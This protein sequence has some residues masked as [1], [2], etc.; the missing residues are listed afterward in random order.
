M[1]PDVLIGVEP[2]LPQLAAKGL[3]CFKTTF[4][5]LLVGPRSSSRGHHRNVATRNRPLDS[6]LLAGENGY[7]W[8]EFGT[9]GI[10]HV[11]IRSLPTAVS[12][13]RTSTS[14]RLTDVAH[15][16]IRYFTAP[17]EIGPQTRATMV[18]LI[19]VQLLDEQARSVSP[20]VFMALIA[21]V[22]LA[23]LGIPISKL[24]VLGRYEKLARSDLALLGFS[25]VLVVFLTTTFLLTVWLYYGVRSELDAELSEDTNEHAKALRAKLDKL[26][27][28]TKTLQDMHR[29]MTKDR[30]V[31]MALWPEAQDCPEPGPVQAS[32]RMYRTKLPLPWDPPPTEPV[33]PSSIAPI[34]GLSMAFIADEQGR[35]ILKAVA[36]DHPTPLISVADRKYFQ[37]LQRRDRSGRNACR[38]SYKPN[39][40]RDKTN[41][42]LWISQSI[43]QNR[44]MALVAAAERGKDPSPIYV[45]SLTGE[46]LFGETN[47]Y[48][49]FSFGIVDQA[50]RHVAHSDDSVMFR[51]D[52][53]AR[54]LPRED[55]EMAL[56]R[57]GTGKDG[58]DIR[59]KEMPVHIVLTKIEGTSYYMLGVCD[60]SLHDVLA[61]DTVIASVAGFGLW[62]L[63]IPLVLLLLSTGAMGVQTLRVLAERDRRPQR[64]SATWWWPMR[65]RER[66]YLECVHYVL[67]MVCLSFSAIILFPGVVVLPAV[68]V[69]LPLTVRDVAR[70]LENTTGRESRR[71]FA[72]VGLWTLPIGN[73]A[74]LATSMVAVVSATKMPG[75]SVATGRIVIFVLL[76]A[77]AG[78]VQY[79]RGAT[80]RAIL[81][82]R[83]FGRRLNLGPRRIYL[84]RAY[85]LL[86]LLTVG[87]LGSV[88]AAAFFSAGYDYLMREMT[89]L[90]SSGG[91]RSSKLFGELP[92]ETAETPSRESS[93]G[94]VTGPGAKLPAAV[95]SN[96]F[97]SDV[98]GEPVKSLLRM[99]PRYRA[100]RHVDRVL[101]RTHNAVRVR[102]DRDAI[103]IE[104]TGKA[105]SRWKVEWKGILDLRPSAPGI[106]LLLVVVALVVVLVARTT[107]TLVRRLFFTS[108]RQ[109]DTLG[110]LRYV[111]ADRQ[112]EVCSGFPS[113][114]EAL[115]FVCP[116]QSVID[117][118]LGDEADKVSE[119]WHDS[120]P[121]LFCRRLFLPAVSLDEL[122]RERLRIGE[123][124]NLGAVALVAEVDP[125]YYLSSLAVDMR[126]HK[127]PA[128]GE[129]WAREAQ[130]WALLLRGFAKHYSWD[131]PAAVEA[132]KR[133]E[134]QFPG[135]D[136]EVLAEAVR[137]SY[138]VHWQQSTSQEK[139]VLAN[140]AQDGLCNPNARDTL[141]QLVYRGLVDPN[142]L[143]FKLRGFG[144]FVRCKSS[145]TAIASLSD[146]RPEPK[147]W[148]LLR[149]P[150][151]AA[152]GGLL[153]LAVVAQ[154]EVGM[155]SLVPA[156][157]GLVVPATGR[158]LL[159]ALGS[160]GSPD[161]A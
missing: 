38:F 155:G 145:P 109:E 131:S 65:G 128:A 61:V 7:V 66:D 56:A 96:E 16:D 69:G 47:S 26:S 14:G 21:L 73:S 83:Y 114:G 43:T 129:A 143:S 117:R 121:V 133:R 159:A 86:V 54:A 152:V 101:A 140:I 74:L 23:I 136:G 94:F 106:M 84:S 139:F 103:L 132:T 102:R 17:V 99:T 154:P 6:I 9:S 62:L 75:A 92:G 100:G 64:A 19:R 39:G 95:E 30:Q 147:R 31:D 160:G 89:I 60:R 148:Q 141:R 120:L 115:L 41:Y 107:A 79:G 161:V 138:E 53:L 27:E 49:G 118:L 104:A 59:Y 3:S 111:D 78:T 149:A 36:D 144:A 157:L 82:R 93:S 22:S 72:T 156:A 5:D 142:D 108:F 55:V 12:S 28:L 29:R 24:A 110:V 116:P 70:R 137:S 98:L 119:G 2:L 151:F 51:E 81:G 4:R 18:G 87:M 1:G 90:H 46:S 125:V 34:V 126:A 25:S 37:C 97:G 134:A 67:V 124:A 130:E 123:V 15:E 105:G 50:G 112:D 76:A 8:L 20:P 52:F 33:S 48:P 153:G 150:V 71:G 13:A 158:L 57:G 146:G 32:L 44:L 42:L 127:G 80:I 113:N 40:P 85:N 63:A 77:A 68:V 135:A 35:Q 10:P 122:A 45:A 58:I 11:E 88:P 91:V